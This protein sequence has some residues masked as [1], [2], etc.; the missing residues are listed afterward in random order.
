MDPAEGEGDEGSRLVR[1]ELR[2]ELES[3]IGG[4]K[5]ELEGIDFCCGVRV[6]AEFGEGEGVVGEVGEVV[7]G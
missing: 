4:V 2:V 1:V 7:V 3:V 5:V 6:A